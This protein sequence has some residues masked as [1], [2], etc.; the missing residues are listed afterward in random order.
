MQNDIHV[1]TEQFDGPLALLLLLIQKQ[2][3]NIRDLNIGEITRQYIELIVHM[4][5]IN[6]D[7]A[8]DY[9]LMAATLLFL[10]SRYCV[11]GNEEKALEG[12]EI[13]EEEISIKS[14]EELVRR[15]L[16]LYKFQKLSDLLWQLPRRDEEIFCRHKVNLS[17]IHI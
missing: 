6:F 16:D 13:S 17:L 10:K 7:L 8:G 2:E 15:L 9:L 11:E 14:K 12:L 1:K 5:E 4:Q 3:M